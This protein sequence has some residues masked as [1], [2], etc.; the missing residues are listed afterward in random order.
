VFHKMQG[1][2]GLTEELLT[3]EEGLRSTGLVNGEQ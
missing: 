1:I 2:S 3:S